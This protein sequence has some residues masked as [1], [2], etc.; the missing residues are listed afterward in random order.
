MGE[1]RCKAAREEVDKLLKAQFI[2]E[3]RYST[4]L[5]NVIMVKKA[6]G[7]WWMCIDYTDLNKACPKEGYPLPNI[8]RL[9]DSASGFQVLS[10]L[11]AYLGYNQNRMH[12][13][14]EEKI[15]FI[16][17]DANFCYRIMPFGLKNASATYQRL[18]D[19][20]FKE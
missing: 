10:F 16:T 12:A 1:E 3:V 15:A 6:N 14:D 9:V 11:D 20:I 17:E 5:A 2:R 18:M 7:K 13:P 8:N 4:W 19:R